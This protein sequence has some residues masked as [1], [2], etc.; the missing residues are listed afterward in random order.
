M[1]VGKPQG[2]VDEQACAVLAG[3]SL[4]EYPAPDM[5]VCTRVLLAHRM[6]LRSIVQDP[7]RQDHKSPHTYQL[8]NRNLQWTTLILLLPLLAR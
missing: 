2:V 8:R 3:V 1:R 6:E 7:P 5:S 4:E